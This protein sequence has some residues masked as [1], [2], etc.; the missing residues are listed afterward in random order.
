MTETNNPG[1]DMIIPPLQQPKPVTNIELQE[2]SE[3][4]Q[5]SVING[6]HSPEVLQG[7]LQRWYPRLSIKVIKN[8]ITLKHDKEEFTFT[9]N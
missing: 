3:S 4:I 5:A 1:G 2:I 8:K 9:L 6:Q 7:M